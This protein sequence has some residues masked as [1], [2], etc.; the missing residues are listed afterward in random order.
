MTL[1]ALEEI[2]IGMHIEKKDIVTALSL[3]IKKE[4]DERLIPTIAE[5]GLNLDSASL[6]LK[7]IPKFIETGKYDIIKSLRENGLEINKPIANKLYESNY[8][9]NGFIDNLELFIDALGFKPCQD[10]VDKLYN[11]N[12]VKKLKSLGFLPSKKWIDDKVNSL[13]D[14]L[15]NYSYNGHHDDEKIK[16]SIQ[17]LGW[18]FN[19]FKVDF[20]KKLEQDVST[21]VEKLVRN[22]DYKK[23]ECLKDLCEIISI[24]KYVDALS[25]EIK[26]KF[27]Q[28]L[29]NNLESDFRD[30]KKEINT[31]LAFGFDLTDN[32]YA[33]T[34]FK[35]IFYDNNREVNGYREDDKKIEHAKKL[36]NVGFYPTEDTIQF[37]YKQLLNNGTSIFTSKHS[38][39]YDIPLI[40]RFYQILNLTN[41]VPSQDIIET[42]YDMC[43]FGKF[44]HHNEYGKKIEPRIDAINFIYETT[45]IAPSKNVLNVISEYMRR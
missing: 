14:N 24:K 45:Q 18:Y 32:D 34:I 13:S 19:N 42:C 20:S 8:Y 12:D 43:T 2:I 23:E 7:Y 21:I 40:N 11:C 28:K 25:D 38:P 15:V 6:M 4:E 16:S 37:V 29:L 17:S 10:I 36:I 27:K 30:P 26:E 3:L 9:R 1:T 44:M 5:H 22:Y 31:A 41:I 33:Q 39:I 35:R